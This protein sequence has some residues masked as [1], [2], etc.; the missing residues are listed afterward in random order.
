MACGIF[1]SSTPEPPATNT[2]NPDPT[3]PPRTQTVAPPV[4]DEGKGETDTGAG[5]K[6]PTE[7]YRE[8]FPDNFIVTR[9]VT[10]KADDDFFCAK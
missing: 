10:V 5:T 8:W 7:C 6:K 1:G 2:P 3:Q 4:Y 9:Y